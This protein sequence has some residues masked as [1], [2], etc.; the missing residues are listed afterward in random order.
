MLTSHGQRDIV[1]LLWKSRE[2]AEFVTATSKDVPSSL[3]TCIMWVRGVLMKAVNSRLALLRDS[4]AEV[5]PQQKAK[6]G[7]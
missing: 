1:L 2:D 6:I 4:Y 5:H 7:E 3:I